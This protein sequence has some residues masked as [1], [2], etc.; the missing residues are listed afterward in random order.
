MN[1]SRCFENRTFHVY[2]NPDTTSCNESSEYIQKVKYNAIYN[3]N[4][5]IVSATTNGLSESQ[6]AHTFGI[7]YPN[8]QLRY[9]TFDVSCNKI[10]YL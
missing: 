4:C 8:Y 6:I 9:D 1:A 5:K 7:K 2:K 10:K 3:Q